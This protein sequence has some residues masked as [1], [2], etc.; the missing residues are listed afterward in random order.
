MSRKTAE[1]FLCDSCGAE[2]TITYDNEEVLD[3]AIYCPFC[4]SELD[5]YDMEEEFEQE[6]NFDED[7]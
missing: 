5:S 7:D 6:L 3:E 4:G 1:E 2:Y